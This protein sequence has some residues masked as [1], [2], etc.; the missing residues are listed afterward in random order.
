MDSAI[1]VYVTQHNTSHSFDE[2]LDEKKGKEKVLEVA[3]IFYIYLKTKKTCY[4]CYE[5]WKKIRYAFILF[6]FILLYD[7]TYIFCLILDLNTYF[8]T[9]L[10]HENTS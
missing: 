3:K 8:S 4:F 7:Y 6:L 9:I 5:T 1:T 10:N 2:M